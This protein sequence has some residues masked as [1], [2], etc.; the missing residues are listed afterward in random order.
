MDGYYLHKELNKKSNGW[1]YNKC[2]AQVLENYYEPGMEIH[3]WEV[4]KLK[5]VRA[6]LETALAKAVSLEESDRRNN[7]GSH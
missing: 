7:A 6:N 5:T 1:K 3:K 4:E 2:G